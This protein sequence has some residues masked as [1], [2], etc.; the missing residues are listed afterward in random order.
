LKGSSPQLLPDLELELELELGFFHFPILI[1]KKP[2][3]SDD[4]DEDFIDEEEDEDEEEEEGD[5]EEGD[6]ED[7]ESEDEELKLMKKREQV[8]KDITLI[9]HIFEYIDETTRRIEEKFEMEDE[10]ERLQTELAEARSLMASMKNNNKANTSTKERML[11]PSSNRIVIDPTDLSFEEY[12]RMD[13]VQRNL[14]LDQAIAALAEGIQGG[15]L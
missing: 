12:D 13:D 7:E 11:A 1:F 2:T 10:L 3:M 9:H 8:Q 6:E 15:N 4:E 14:L 5:E